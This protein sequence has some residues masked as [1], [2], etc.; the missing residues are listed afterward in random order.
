M[1]QK[2]NVSADKEFHYMLSLI[3]CLFIGLM[4]EHSS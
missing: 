3:G 4:D 1:V 2:L